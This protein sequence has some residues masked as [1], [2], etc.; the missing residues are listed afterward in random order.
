MVKAMAETE[1]YKRHYISLALTF[2]ISEMLAFQI[3]Y[4][5]N[6]GKHDRA[7]RAQLCHLMANINVYKSHNLHFTQA[8]NRFRDVNVSN[9]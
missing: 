7:Y 4:L 2:A 3:V 6:L 1:I 8:L 9:V 5:E